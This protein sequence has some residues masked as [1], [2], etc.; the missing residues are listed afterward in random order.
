MVVKKK[1]KR[2]DKT[3]QVMPTTAKPSSRILTFQLLHSKFN[4]DL[5]AWSPWDL[6]SLASSS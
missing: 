2:Y 6:T 1:E 5:P 4:L 3:A